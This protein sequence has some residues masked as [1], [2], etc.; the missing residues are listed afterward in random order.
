MPGSTTSRT[1]AVT[2]ALAQTAA[3][4]TAHALAAGCLPSAG[5]LAL[6]VPLSL[7]GVLLLGRLLPRSPLL[8]LAGGQLA[9]HLALTLAAACSAHVHVG[10]PA[11]ALAH[12]VA[13]VL[14]RALLD[15]VVAAVEHAA[16]RLRRRW[17]S[18]RVVVLVATGAVRSGVVVLRSRTSGGAVAGRGPPRVLPAS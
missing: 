11:A 17:T 8:R 6:A 10:H 1:S 2:A 18:V 12:V 16:A 3:A 14:C 4:V 15:R 13:L 7:A 9:G 5:G